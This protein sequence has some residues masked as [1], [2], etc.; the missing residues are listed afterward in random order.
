MGEPPGGVRRGGEHE[1]SLS[2]RVADRSPTQSES[3][4]QTRGF[5]VA[6]RRDAV[7]PAWRLAP[8]GHGNGRRRSLPVSTAAKYPAQVGRAAMARTIC[9]ARDAGG[10][11][12]S[13]NRTTSACA[14]TTMI[15]KFPKSLS[16]RQQHPLFFL[17]PGR[18]P[19]RQGFRHRL[20]ES[21]RHRGPPPAMREPPQAGSFHSPEAAS[22]TIPSETL[23]ARYR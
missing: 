14:A 6:R 11:S 15:H 17:P 20:R 18:A 13:L 1:R 8:R 9:R 19:R 23:I 21:T 5:V 7:E 3:Q 4:H 2:V 12:G 10:A 16:K 22:T